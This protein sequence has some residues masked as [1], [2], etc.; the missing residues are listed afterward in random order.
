MK[1]FILLLFIPLVV[2]C[3][4]AVSGYA[5]V[6]TK[7]EIV[8]SGSMVKAS[9]DVVAA[10]QS[11]N[12]EGISVTAKN[13][14]SNKTTVFTTGEKVT[15]KYGSYTLSADYY[16]ANTNYLNDYCKAADEPFILVSTN[17]TISDTTTE[18]IISATYECCALL[19]PASQVSRFLI[20]INGWN[21]LPSIVAGDYRITFL[22]GTYENS[23]I[24]ICEPVDDSYNQRQISAPKADKS[25]GKYFYIELAP[26]GAELDP[27]LSL[28]DWTEGSM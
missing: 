11:C 5:V 28:P 16:P 19:A 21:E 10:I 17:S 12:P 9:S 20:N 6:S 22:R 14:E 4:K 23:H 27:N 26:S 13:T 25:R 18:L 24:I 8:E 1:K 2:S 15:L 3:E 7:Y